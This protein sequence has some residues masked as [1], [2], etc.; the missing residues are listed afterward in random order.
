M[1][2]FQKG[3]NRPDGAGRKAGTPNKTT[4]ECK[5][6][7]SELIAGNMPK[8]QTWLDKIAEDD[9]AK[10]F[11]LLI[12]MMEFSVPKLSRIESKDQKPDTIKQISIEFIKC[13]KEDVI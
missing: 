3:Q 9:P 1:A 6:A 5:E 12:K 7:I 4:S 2:K 13:K 10:A 8:L 11:D